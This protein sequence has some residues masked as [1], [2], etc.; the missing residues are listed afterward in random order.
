MKLI[1]I[2]IQDPTDSKTISLHEAI[3]Y[4]CVNAVQGGGAFAF[5]TM[6]GVK[7]LLEDKSFQ[8]FLENGVFNLIIGIDQVTDTKTINRLSELQKKQPNLSVFAF[9][10]DINGSLFHPKLCWFKTPKGGIVIMGSGNLTASALRRNW[11]SYNVLEFNT[12]EFT[13]IESFW[14]DWF[15]KNK[16]RLKPLDDEIVIKKAQAN[17]LKPRQKV[18]EEIAEEPVKEVIEQQTSSEQYQEALEDQVAWITNDGDSVLIAEIP[19][20]GDRWKQVN[21]HKDNFLDFFG[22]NPNDSSQRVLFRHLSFDGVTGD[23]E[24]RPSVSVKSQNYR[25]ELEAASGLEYPSTGRP[26]GIF[27]RVSTRMFIYSLVMPG[28]RFYQQ[29]NAYLA[30]FRHANESQMRRAETTVKKLKK[31]GINLPLPVKLL[32]GNK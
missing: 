28:N 10:H 26:I 21:F 8:G 30:S 17:I 15:N 14:N 3:L 11:E 9:D 31:N 16:S 4:S 27:V 23:I 18:I 12:S 24:I 7:L 22:A 13:K 2:D 25:F 32:T 6:G 1:H 19:R 5:V 20:S 29:V